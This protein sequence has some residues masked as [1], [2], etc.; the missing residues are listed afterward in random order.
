MSQA[1]SIKGM[2]GVATAFNQPLAGWDVRGVTDMSFLFWAA[3]SFNQDLSSWSLGP[4]VDARGMFLFAESFSQDLC[5]W[6]STVQEAS[7]FDLAF[8]GTA[9][10]MQGNSNTTVEPRGPFCFDCGSPNFPV[11]NRSS[12]WEIGSLGIGGPQDHCVVEGNC[13]ASH[14]RAG[15]EGYIADQICGFASTVPG[16]LVVELFDTEQSYDYLWFDVGDQVLLYSGSDPGGLNNRAIPAGSWIVWE[17]D[18]SG[19]GLGWKLCLV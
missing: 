19:A 8:A 6:G 16:T 4:G 9:C 10:P 14:A 17:S 15:M 11:T 12:V 1:T 13:T 7:R 3:F 5:G 18:A 2:L